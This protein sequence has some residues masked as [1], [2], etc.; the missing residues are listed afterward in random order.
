M[1][2]RRWVRWERRDLHKRIAAAFLIA[3]MFSLLL[4]A[5][6]AAV[7]VTAKQTSTTPVQT[8]DPRGAAPTARG[9][10]GTLRILNWQAPT[11]LNVHLAQGGKDYFAG[12]LVN[13]P[14]ATIS[15]NAATPDIPVLARDIPTA[16]NGGIAPDG[17]RVTWKL[18]EGVTWSDGTPFTATDVR[19]TYQFI[20]RP[21]SAAST[22]NRFSAVESVEAPDDTTVVITFK[23]ATALWY[24]PFG[25][26]MVVLQAA[27]LASCLGPQNCPINQNPLGTGPYKVRSFMPGDNVQYIINDRYREANA[28]YFDAVDLKGG[29]DATTAA[30]AVQ[31]GQADYA[32]NLQV[33]PDILQQLAE[34]GR[35]IDAYGGNGVEAITLNFADPN[36]EVDGEKSSLKAPHPFQTD[37][38]VREA[39]RYLID[40]EAIAKNLYGPAGV[41]TCNVLGSV[42]PQL[43]SPNT[44]CG[45]DVARANRLLDEAGYARGADGV[46]AKG[47]VRLSVAITTSINAVRE[48]Q[49]QVMQQAFRQAGIELNIRNAESGVFFGPP[50]NPDAASRFEKDM[51]ISAVGNG[52][53][54]PETFFT[55]LTTPRIAQKANGW[56]GDNFGRY[57]DPQYDALAAQL[58]RERDPQRRIDLAIQCNDYLVNNGVLL[59]LVDRKTTNGRR[60][61]LLGTNATPW[62]SQSWNIAYWQINR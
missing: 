23:N 44:T 34:S 1:G 55:G 2:S 26:N 52:L 61:D 22:V 36:R 28:P 53:P 37:P 39:Y 10:G 29:G 13:E 19:A 4:A 11:I 38:Q 41:A 17:K 6:P 47:G 8:G 7:L 45:F 60:P 57:S 50:D 59:P 54:D 15:I 49:E 43:S 12:R 56:K 35:A 5:M 24:L 33:T 31:T 3:M 40:R 16:Q 62:D 21:E 20:V 25:G 9:G 42:P 51:Q 32:W 27:Q 48:K 30:K 46:R 18:R 14:L 58:A